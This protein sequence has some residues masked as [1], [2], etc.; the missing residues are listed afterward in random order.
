MP[1]SAPCV[2]LRPLPGTKRRQA[3][4]LEASGKHIHTSRGVVGTAKFNK[5]GPNQVSSSGLGERT[6]AVG[7]AG[8]ASHAKIRA[9]NDASKGLHAPR[10]LTL[11]PRPERRYTRDARNPEK[12]RSPP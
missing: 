11:F 1:T 8:R 5:A 4:P 9:I 12:S 7:W 2:P 6:P 3:G 10:K